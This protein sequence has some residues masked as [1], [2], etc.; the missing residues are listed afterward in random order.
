MVNKITPTSCMVLDSEATSADLYE[1]IHERLVK[2]QG[3]LA[4]IIAEDQYTRISDQCLSG[5]LWAIT[6]QID[7]A[8]AMCQ[9]LWDQMHKS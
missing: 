9:P 6:A 7:E 3:S 1:A 8:E 5:I 2:A 4:A